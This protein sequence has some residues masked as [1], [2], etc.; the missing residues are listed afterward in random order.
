M[1]LSAVAAV[2][3]A[4]AVAVADAVTVSVEQNEA[5]DVDDEAGNADVQHPVCVLDLVHVSQALNRFH[6]DREAE[7]DE[8]DG[9]DEG[10][11]HLGTRPA[12][13]VLVRVHL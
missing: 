4:V 5:D 12:V 7:R 2:T 13:R 3:V 11:E 6:E 9:I 8:E 10:A 1:A